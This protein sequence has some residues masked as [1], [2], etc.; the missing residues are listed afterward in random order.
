MAL[1]GYAA[2]QERISANA[3]HRIIKHHAARSGGC[4]CQQT[5][6]RACSRL[7]IHAS[8]ALQIQAKWRARFSGTRIADV[9]ARSA[10]LNDETT[11]RFQKIHPFVPRSPRGLRGVTRR[12]SRL[13]DEAR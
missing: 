3:R 7:V 8:K 12:C 10:C 13:L 4:F 1:R 9:T 5:E 11:S 6:Q 2:L